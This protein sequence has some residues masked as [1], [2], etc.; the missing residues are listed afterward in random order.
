[1]EALLA[2]RQLSLSDLELLTTVGVGTFGRVRLAKLRGDQSEHVFALK[3]MKKSVII[4]LKQIAHVKSEKT[5][6]E[7]L[8]SPFI[9]RLYASF[10]T[11]CCL[12]FL[13]E[14]I[15]G[16]ELFKRLRME[17][18]FPNDVG[19]FYAT[20]VVCAFAYLHSKSI[21]YRDLKPE[22]IL[23]DREG[24]LKLVDFG[25]A[26]VV[27][28]RTFTLCGTPEYLAPESITHKG[29]DQGVDWWALGILVYE[30]LVGNPPFFDDNPYNLYQLILQCDLSVPAHVH[31]HAKSFITQ[32]LTVDRV[33]RLG[34][35]VRTRQG[36]EEVKS[37]RWFR[38]VDFEL[39]EERVIPTPWVPEV[40]RE[41][42]TSQFDEYPDSGEPSLPD[43]PAGD[44]FIDF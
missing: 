23:I 17:G 18:Q 4:R 20:E 9:P 19:L 32:C 44:P 40:E 29:H 37:H 2:G 3:I 39:V 30:M 11:P 16:G 14:Y 33:R 41:D 27:T 13:T 25:F 38:G 28:D 43:L 36:A 12:Y 6:L 24:H 5:V 26:K 1:M 8:N 10:Q 34:A 31:P 42:D 7:T 15:P 22:N 21:A 35:R